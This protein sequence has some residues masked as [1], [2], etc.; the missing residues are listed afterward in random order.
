MPTLLPDT[1][2]TGGSSIFA[3]SV[4]SGLPNFSSIQLFV[5]AQILH[6]KTPSSCVLVNSFSHKINLSFLDYTF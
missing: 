5:Q 4:S 2:H 1:L 3:D 6:A